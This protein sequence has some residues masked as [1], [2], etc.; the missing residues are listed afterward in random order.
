MTIKDEQIEPLRVA[1][2][3]RVSTEEQAERYGPNL[4]KDSLLGLIRSRGKL[5][6]KK[7][8][9]EL[10][11]EQYIY[12]DDG[13]SGT[14]N[15]DERPAFSKLKEDVL[16]APDGVKPFDIVAVY[17][18]DRFAR[19]LSV[20]LDIIEFFETNEIKFISANESIDTSTPFGRA[21]LGIIGVIAELEIQTIKMRT[22]DG[23]MQAIKRGVPMGTFTT[24][25]YTKGEDKLRKVFEEEAQTVREIFNLFV[26]QKRTPDQI[27]QELRMREILSPEASAS[28]HGKKNGTLRKKSSIHF[29]RPDSVLNILKDEIYIGK[30]YYNKGKRGEPNPKEAWQLSEA[31]APIIIDLATFENAQRLLETTRHER[32]QTLTGHTYLLS[33]LLRCEACYEASK[34]TAMV[35]WV[36]ERK[37]IGKGS[38]KF[39]YAY[40][41]GRKNDRKYEETC[42][43][44]P[45]P[46]SEIERY[47]LEFC[48]KIIKNPKATYN[49][50]LQLQS[51]KQ[52]QIHL[53]KKLNELTGL[54][55]GIPAQRE[56]LREMREDGKISREAL[57]ARFTEIASK[58][59]RLQEELKKTQLE[60]AQDALTSGAITA[61]GAFSLK[62]KAGINKILN[63][64]KEAYTLLHELIEEI[65]V[66][67]RPLSDKDVIAGKR[68]KDQ[69]IPSRLHIK[70]K[71]PQ[72]LLQSLPTQFG[73][74]TTHLSG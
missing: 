45:L 21:V 56:R 34:G 36:G 58:E 41:C 29:W 23:R 5:A 2:Y 47:I 6:N 51:S 38:G 17:K 52:T 68:K 20:L 53:T 40:K 48:K 61:L 54:L 9:L 14:T 57:D 27:A 28:A 3:I 67:S 18:I 8:V 10:A 64:R 69:K 25:G 74:E 1:L 43:T 62:Y 46:A 59:K 33:G 55:N 22:Q 50:Q 16:H 11:G 37:E 32:K 4:Q 30:I 72:E 71:L 65:V 39:T 60:L 44:L 12:M 49:H 63:D 66:S 70:L 26:N 15:P 31:R 73:V 19:K 24:Y 7:D 13:V 35:H 42:N